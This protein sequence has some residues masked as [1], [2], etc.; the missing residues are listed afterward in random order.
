MQQY[1]YYI[2]IFRKE[3]WQ[4]LRMIAVGETFHSLLLKVVFRKFIASSSR[5][6]KGKVTLLT[7]AMKNRIELG[8]RRRQLLT[9]MSRS[10]LQFQANE[11]EIWSKNDPTYHTQYTY[12]ECVA[13][14]RTDL[15]LGRVEQLVRCMYVVAAQHAQSRHCGVAAVCCD[16]G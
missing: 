4:V 16:V 5:K 12:I 10:H 13:D 7:T 14:E 6:G 3:Q 8:R 11:R 15:D 9:A 1:Q 2:F